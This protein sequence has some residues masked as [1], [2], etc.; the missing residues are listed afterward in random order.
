[1]R[2]VFSLLFLSIIQCSTYAQTTEIAA[3]ESDNGT[4]VKHH[5]DGKTPR[6]KG[7]PEGHFFKYYADGAIKEKGTMVKYKYVDVLERYYQNGELKELHRFD[8]EGQTLETTYYSE[9]GCPTLFISFDKKTGKTDRIKY[10]EAD[11][12][13]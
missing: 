4:W 6:I 11:C 9:E 3:S 10:E 12:K 7:E 1:M 13:E 5:E 8:G 2:F